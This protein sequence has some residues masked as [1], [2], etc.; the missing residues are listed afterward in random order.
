MTRVRIKQHAVSRQ[1]DASVRTIGLA[2]RRGDDATCAAGVATLT[3]L[4]SNGL[5][6]ATQDSAAFLLL[7]ALTTDADLP[8]KIDQ[9]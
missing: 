7:L 8:Q 5:T 3:D 2:A 6:F 4:A 9:H 1:H